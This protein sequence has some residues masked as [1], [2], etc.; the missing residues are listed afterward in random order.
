[1]FKSWVPGSEE[2][3]QGLRMLGSLQRTL[4]FQHPYGVAHNQLLVTTTPGDHKPCSY[5]FGH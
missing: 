4:G 5:I 3:A 1:M 2:I